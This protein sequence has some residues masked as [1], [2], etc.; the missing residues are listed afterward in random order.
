MTSDKVKIVKAKTLWVCDA[1]D[2]K[3]VVVIQNNTMGGAQ[4]FRFRMWRF[5][6]SSEEQLRKVRQRESCVNYLV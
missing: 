5:F 2:G 3:I 6:R 1:I 4:A